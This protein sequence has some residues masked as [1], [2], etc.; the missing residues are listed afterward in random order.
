L[1]PDIVNGTRYGWGKSH[2][3]ESLPL[4]KKLRRVDHLVHYNLH[5]RICLFLPVLLLWKLIFCQV[6]S[7]K[8]TRINCDSSNNTQNFVRIYVLGVRKLKAVELFYHDVRMFYK[9]FVH[10][11]FRLIFHYIRKNGSNL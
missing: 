4:S 2:A 11:I 7:D 9:K 3:Q 5:S 10:A 1:V 8:I 6:Q